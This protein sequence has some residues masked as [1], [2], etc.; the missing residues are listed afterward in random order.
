MKLTLEELDALAWKTIHEHDNTVMELHR[1]YWR[2]KEAAKKAESARE[3]TTEDLVN[4]IMKERKCQETSYIW[5]L[6]SM[7]RLS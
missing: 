2:E 1:A 3:R 4:E 6:A 5:P 7:L